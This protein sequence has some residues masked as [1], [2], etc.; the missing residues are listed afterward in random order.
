MYRKYSTRGGVEWQ[1]Q[2]EVKLSAV[3][4]QDLTPST[5][6]FHTS[7]VNGDLLF[8]VER[9][10]SSNRPGMDVYKETE[11]IVSDSLLH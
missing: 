7:R 10:S 4:A 8:C 3:F 9:I 11:V 2:H 1:I 5:V 6:L